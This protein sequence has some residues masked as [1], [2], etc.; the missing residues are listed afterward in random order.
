MH[1]INMDGIEP[2]SGFKNVLWW[3]CERIS[4]LLISASVVMQHEMP[5]NMSV[6]RVCDMRETWYFG[7]LLM[8]VLLL[9]QNAAAR[10]ITITY[11][12]TAS[13]MFSLV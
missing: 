5:S 4:E 1:C 7:F 11:L 6:W 10:L 2:R 9:V 3:E 12:L 13:F 8:S